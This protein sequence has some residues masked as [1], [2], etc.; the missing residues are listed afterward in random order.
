MAKNT[1]PET[2][3]SANLIQS[4][5]FITGDIQSNG[6]I[7]IDG[8]LNG[9]VY[10]GGK[11]ILGSTGT[12]DGEIKCINADIEGKVTGTIQVKELLSF[13]ATAVVNGEIYTGKLA[14]E[15]GAR[16][17]GTC[18]MDNLNNTEIPVSYAEQQSE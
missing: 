18:R 10:A 17:T 8:T 7:R 11:V 13:K 6:N 14:I 2:P 12:V 3:S 1:I 5:T 15:P 4:G 9:T 16:F